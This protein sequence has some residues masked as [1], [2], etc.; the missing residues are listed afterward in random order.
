M[1]WYTTTTTTNNNNN[2]N[3]SLYY[4]RGLPHLLRAEAPV[5]VL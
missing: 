3:V 2:N 4:L 5:R 1:I